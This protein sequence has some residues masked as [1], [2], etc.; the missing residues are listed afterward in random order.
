M[1]QSMGSRRVGHDLVTQQLVRRVTVSAAAACVS[2][3]T[4]CLVLTAPPGT[5]EE[6]GALLA[7]RRRGRGGPEVGV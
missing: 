7:S 3:L 5:T 6:M 4:A 1:L 2:Q